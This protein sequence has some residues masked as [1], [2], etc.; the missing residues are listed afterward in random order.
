MTI[1]ATRI[2]YAGTL[3][4]YVLMTNYVHLL[5]TPGDATG[6]SRMMQSL[7]RRYVPYVNGAYR[8]TGTLSERRYRT[9]PIEAEAHL[10]ACMRYIELTPVRARTV[11]KL[12]DYPC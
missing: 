8:R 5:A 11:R 7:G 1:G 10:L 4:A 3:H 9:G 6:L 2:E 12:A